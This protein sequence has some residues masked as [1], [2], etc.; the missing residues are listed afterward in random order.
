MIHKFSVRPVAGRTPPQVAHLRDSLGLPD[1]L[2]WTDYYVEFPAAPGAA[3][4]E[5]VAGT[6]SDGVEYEVVVDQP[7]DA[8][9]VQVAHRSGIVDNESDSMVAF[10][11]FLGIEATAAKAAITYR[12]GA[13]GLAE[14]VRERFCNPNIEEF[15]DA[16]PA[17]TSLRPA[18]AYEPPRTLDLLDLDDEA[19]T[20]VGTADGRNLTLDK[21]RQLVH[22][23]AKLGLPH[24]TDVLLEA[25]DA[26][27][28]DHCSHTTWRSHGNL[29]RRLVAAAEATANPNI[30][31]MFH[32]NA[33]VWD[34]YDGWALAI[35]AETHN[36]PSAVSA[37]FGQLTKL[38]G[39]LRDILG[40]GLGADPI[41]CFE[42]TAT[43]VPGDPAPLPGRPDP[44][45]IAVETVRAIKEYGNTFGVPMM[46]SRMAFHR[47]Y[48]AK[49]FAL[50][51]SVGLLPAAAA[52]RGT[53][54][55]GDV[56][57]LIGGLTGNEGIHG[58]SASSAGATMDEAAVQIGA[59]LEQVK[60]RN[61]ILELRDAGC[62]RAL[63]DV[64]GAGLNSAAGEIG[65][66]CGIWVNTA[67]VQL[68][69]SA[70]PMWRILLSES[71]ERMLLAV[72]PEQWARAKALCERHF[73]RASVIGRFVSTGRYTV[74]HDPAMGEAGALAAG[75]AE[76]PAHGGDLGFDIPYE[77]L[78]YEPAAVP[79]GA[80]PASSAAPVPLPALPADRFPGVFEAVLADP[81][82]ASQ[83][84]ADSQYD[85]TVQG[86]SVYGPRFGRRVP[87]PS[88]YWA[89][90]P[91][92]DSPA[93][94]VLSTAFSPWL[95]EVQPV[96]ALRQ[97]FC[98]LLLGQVLAGVQLRDIC[99]C[100]NFYTPHLVPDAGEWLVALV[101]ELAGL[102][103]HFGT[104]VIS[105]KDSSAGSTRVPGGVL[106]VPHG[107]FLTALGK[108]PDA[109]SLLPEAWQESGNLLVRLGPETPSAAGTVAG[110]VLGVGGG[111]LDVVDLSAYLAFLESV[112]AHRHLF[113][114][115]ALIGAG[116]VAARLFTNAVAGDLGV[117]LSLLD[118]TE[119]LVEHRCGA[120]VEVSDAGLAAL[121][122]E[123]RPV[124]VGR[125]TD[126]T[127]VRAG[128][129]DLVSPAAVRAWGGS[130][131]EALA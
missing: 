16:E 11:A 94:A 100:D 35:K 49:P 101:D 131:E 34:F 130:F 45:H 22:A 9:S 55:P 7:L 65:E 18:G 58:A 66:A 63:T 64:G 97:M 106:S 67:L 89:A 103:R 37:Y 21:M 38:G 52:A 125:L 15:H 127:G 70:L 112:A 6:L 50:G 2:V 10:C 98:R 91:I 39:V 122:P 77:L 124:V 27:W 59:P 26:R 105:G 17:Y 71:Q 107:V 99:V 92:P 28:S 123:L 4:L 43:G 40:T 5:L 61:A 51:G 87:V 121:P 120:L 75:G 33:G 13:A 93:A 62:L 54:R 69:T 46:W 25:A 32:D 84:F 41:G 23:Q 20:R 109:P 19:L 126:R 60:F 104:P 96:R 113:R 80:V 79:V 53:P 90:T 1:L 114:S 3:D 48:A 57:V 36:G 88:G 31:S 74:F 82:V 129:A 47:A 102:V 72:P 95:Y 24:L 85:S 116:G 76:P 44:R 14:V 110:R 111:S 73:V 8:Q 29:L 42:Y 68:K 128:S 78:D 81:E 119:L 83:L 12:S 86:N 56:V 30:L 118:W 115:G 108:V 117:S